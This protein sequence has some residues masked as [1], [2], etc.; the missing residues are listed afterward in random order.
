MSTDK[1][2]EDFTDHNLKAEK[3]QSG[4]LK[5]KWVVLP[6][7]W[8]GFKRICFTLGFMILLSSAISIYMLSQFEGPKAPKIPDTGVLYLEFK[9]G[10]SEVQKTP[11]FAAPF[12]PKQPTLRDYVMAIDKAADDPRIV[13][14]VA[15]MYNG[16]FGLAHVQEIRA[17]L[18]RFKEAKK[19]T[20]IYSTSYGEGGGGLGRFY[21]ASAFDERWM[22][23]MGIVAISGIRAEVPFLHDVLDKVGIQPQFMQKKEYKSAYESVTRSE[24]SDENR[25]TLSDIVNGMRA[26]ILADVPRDLGMSE[27]AFERL[28]DKGLFTADKALAAGLVT[29][30]NHVDVLSSKIKMD[31]TGDADSEE[32]IFV[33]VSQ[34][35]KSFKPKHENALMAKKDEASK[36][37]QV[38]LIYAVGAIMSTNGEDR[39]KDGVAAAEII[40]PAIMEAAKD[41]SIQAIVLRVD[42]P[43]G[44]P[45]ASESILRAVEVAKENGKP[46]IVSMGATAASGGYWISAYADKIYALPTTITGSIGVVGGKVALQ[47]L[48]NKIGVNWDRSVSWGENSGIWSF[49]TPFSE[50]EAAQMDAM[51]DHI[52]DSFVTRVAKGRGMDYAAA[53]KLAH[54]RVWTGQQ[55]LDVGLVDEIGGLE[56][57]LN[58]AAMQVNEGDPDAVKIVVM[59]KPKSFQDQLIEMLSRSGAVYE[60]MRMQGQIAEMFQP[61]VREMQVMGSGEAALVYEPLRVE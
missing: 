48:W 23:P 41:D 30:I 26:A 20:R 4:K 61:M 44:S 10:V 9:D 57:A 15:R 54:G 49:N 14:I 1:K 40:A 25:E 55:A 42:S 33:G 35:V 22:Q 13:G 46:V 16:D 52:Y 37:P 50:S 47:E 18:T 27:A 5:R 36:D 3:P 60:G 59:P 51:L 45:S 24:M 29:T 6:F 38:A 19:F 58:Y 39:A 17:A 32:N 11:S 2:T 34:Y 28:V 8:G 43:G 7:L 56:E 53:E 31:L 21:L 12:V